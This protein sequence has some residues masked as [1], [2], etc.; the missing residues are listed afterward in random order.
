M[1][2]AVGFYKYD[3]PTALEPGTNG[4]RWGRMKLIPLFDDE[5]FDAVGQASR[6][7]L[8]LKHRLGALFVRPRRLSPKGEGEF[9]DGDRRDACPTQAGAI[10]F[11]PADFSFGSNCLELAW[12]RRQLI[13]CI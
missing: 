11:L 5:H 4:Q 2:C 10:Q 1:N 6:L 7:S 12:Q 8:T 3:A 13:Y 9:S